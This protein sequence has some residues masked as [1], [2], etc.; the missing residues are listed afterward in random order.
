MN[1]PNGQN[2]QSLVEAEK[3][4]WLAKEPLYGDMEDFVMALDIDLKVVMHKVVMP[5]RIAVQ[6]KAVS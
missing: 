6:K 4:L 3:E 2:V 5:E 1:G